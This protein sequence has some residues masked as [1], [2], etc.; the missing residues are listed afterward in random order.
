MKN[1]YLVY[2]TGLGNDSIGYTF[3][4]NLVKLANKGAVLQEGKVP[5]LR[6][7]YS[8]WLEYE[9]DEEMQDEPGIRYQIVQ[10]TLSKEQLEALDWESF[11]RHLRRVGITGRDRSLMTSKYLKQTGQEE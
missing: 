6:F 3:A 7:P 4:K 1:K 8:A 5:C 10:E 2:V 11:K 9:T